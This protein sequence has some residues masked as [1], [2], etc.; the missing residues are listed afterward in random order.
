[1]KLNLERQTGTG[2]TKLTGHILHPE[3]FEREF[4]AAKPADKKCQTGK[5]LADR[6]PR[7]WTFTLKAGLLAHG[8]TLPPAFPAFA[9]GMG[10]KAR[11]L[12]LRG[13]LRHCPPTM[14]KRTGFPS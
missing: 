7:P 11:R 4:G 12:Q 13:Q 2:G 3:A 1:M 9:S 8:S 5:L 14:G 6:T 10:R